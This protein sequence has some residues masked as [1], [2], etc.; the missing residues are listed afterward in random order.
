MLAP[1]RAC[2]SSAL[3]AVTSAEAMRSSRA[4]ALSAAGVLSALAFFGVVP[5][6]GA[7]EGAAGFA[8]GV[9]DTVGAAAVG[10][11]AV[12]TGAGAT[13][14]VSHGLALSPVVSQPHGGFKISTDA[15]RTLSQRDG[16]GSLNA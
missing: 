10:A 16:Y 13:A 12:G 9:E 1:G 14:A 11:A 3:S 5:A 2:T 6:E 4:T 7:V 15:S 8:G